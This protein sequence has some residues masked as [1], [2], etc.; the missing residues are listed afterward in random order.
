MAPLRVAL[1][2]QTPPVRFRQHAG[3]ATGPGDAPVDLRDLREGVDYDWTV[4]GVSLMLRQLLAKTQELKLWTASMWVALNP[5]GPRE[6]VMDGAR[7]RSVMLDP[8]ELRA[9]AS[10]K[11]KLWAEIHGFAPPGGP[12]TPA[13]FGDFARYNWRTARELL[14]ALPQSDVVYVHDFQLLQLGGMLGLAS[15]VVLRWHGPFRPASWSASFRNFVVRAL[16]SFDGV[17]VSCRRD[18][19]GLLS[20]GYRGL[21]RQVY[22]YLD[23]AAVAVASPAEALAFGE[24]HGIPADAPV[25]LCVSR[26]DPIKGQDRLLRA[27][28]AV[29]RKLPEAR[30]VLVGNGSFSGSAGAGLGVSRGARWREALETE[31][32]ALG[33]GQAVTFTGHLPARDLE[34]ALARCQL[35]VQPSVLEGFALTVVEAW[36]RGKPVVVSQGAGVSELVNQGVNG[37]VYGAEDTDA[38]ADAVLDIL[39]NPG[40]GARMG[41]RGRE[42]AQRCLLE[43]GARAETAVLEEAIA[44]F[45]GA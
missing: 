10:C 30:L 4:G 9:Y 27:F 32:A 24:R 22:P 35:L 14:D 3:H 41:R 6:M 29:R 12:I 26:M 39:L 33:L 23:P 40:T 1:A 45:R 18:L 8:A 13:E 11:E 19:E 5:L 36:L 7:T 42:T 43:R 20:I 16:E 38:L 2:S 37:Y 31:A 21:A 28:V 17:I 25:V 15:P 44:Q 34:A